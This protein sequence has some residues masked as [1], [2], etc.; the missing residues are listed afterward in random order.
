MTVARTSACFDRKPARFSCAFG[1]AVLLAAILGTSARALIATTYTVN[2]ESALCNNDII[3][4]RAKVVSVTT[5]RNGKYAK[6]SIEIE[7]VFCGDKQSIGKLFIDEYKSSDLRGKSAQ[8]LFTVGEEGIWILRK[9]S[10]EL[11]PG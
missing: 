5:E 9:E 10:N 7:Q 11:C 8:S 2:D 6:A 4:V 3:L 1:A